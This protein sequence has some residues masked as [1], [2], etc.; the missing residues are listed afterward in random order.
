MLQAVTPQ[1]DELAGWEFRGYNLH[2]G[3][4]IL[5]IRKF[6]KGFITANNQGWML[7][8]Y[9]VAVLQNGLLNPW[10][11]ELAHGESIRHFP[12]KVLSPNTGGQREVFSHALVLDYALPSKFPLDPSRFLI[13]FLVQPDPHRPD[14]LLGK[15]YGQVGPLRI[16]LSHFVLER[17]NK[18]LR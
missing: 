4:E 9:N 18:V 1:G 11:D 10:V 14:L 6:K 17:Y 5:Q 3:T 16:P 15:A 12:F 8:G 7:D 2:L 13:D